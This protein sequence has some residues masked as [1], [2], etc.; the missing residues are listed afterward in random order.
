MLTYRQEI[1][2][3]HQLG[4][5]NC[6]PV[7]LSCLF[8]ISLETLE[9]IVECKANKGTYTTKVKEA[10]DNE[11]IEC[12]LVSLHDDH[13]NHLWWLEQASHRWPIYLGCHFVH[14]GKRGRPINAHHAV[15]LAGGM[16]YDGNSHREEPINAVCQ[17]FNKKFIVKDAII[18]HHELKTW[19]KTSEAA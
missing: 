19:R 1:R 10:M 9:N 4:A 14:Q 16:I 17:N 8:D 18:F 15:L 6:G 12:S 13:S 11:G 5:Y 2:H 7:A 3:F